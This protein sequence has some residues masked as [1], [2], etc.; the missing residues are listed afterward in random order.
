MTK[1]THGGRR[2]GAGRP[3]NPPVLLSGLPATDCPVQWLLA[4]VNHA[5]AP[6][7][8]RVD[9]AKALMPYF[10]KKPGNIGKKENAADA[11]KKAAGGKFAPS[12]PPSA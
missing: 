9:A 2:A 5:S 1:G 8:L 10:H 6:L 12:A 3:H 7:R 11:A 4:L